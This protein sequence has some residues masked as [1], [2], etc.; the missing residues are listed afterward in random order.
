MSYYTYIH[1]SPD[2]EVFYVGKGTGRR[3]Y[4]MRDRSWI[5]R[6]RFNQFDGITMKIVSR[7]ET[8]DA[9][10][11]HEQELVRYYKDKGCDLV[12]LTEGGAGPNGYYQS[13]ETRAKKSALLRG[14]KHQ[15]VTC[16]HCNEIGGGT[17]MYRWH[18]NNC[19]GSAF[20][21]KAR[22]TLNGERV[23][24]G[25]FATKE[26]ADAV[27]AKFYEEHP[28]PKIYRKISEITRKKMSDAQK[29]HPGS[30][31][32]KEAKQRMAE[33]R[34]G[35]KN[36]FFGHKH[37][38]NT[39]DI[40]GSK[41]KGRQGYWAGKSFSSEHLAKL[42]IDRTCPHCG[43]KGSGSAMNRWHMDNC[44]FKSEAA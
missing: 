4:S 36:P 8:E 23:Y 20:K 9:A 6:E 25:K 15:Q 44:K 17:S 31:W 1:A 32:T 19:T 16:P 28:K 24:L 30:A 3:V 2:G 42:K 14:Y 26:E 27:V 41:G 12:N 39:R 21:F 22:A 37:T 10:F 34:K 38:Q 43:V 33:I 35:D 11:Q 18:F 5:W 40:I 7:F 29:G 13:P